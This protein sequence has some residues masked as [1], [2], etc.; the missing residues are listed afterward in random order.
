MN[1]KSEKLQVDKFREAARELETDED[2]KRFDERLGKIAKTQQPK[3]TS[4]P[5]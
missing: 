4:K 3:A 5:K 1:A 2:E